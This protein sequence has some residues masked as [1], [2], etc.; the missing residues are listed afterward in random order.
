MATWFR[1]WHLKKLHWS[2]LLFCLAC[3]KFSV[4]DLTHK[5]W[6]TSNV[7]DD[8][9]VCCVTLQIF[10]RMSG[11]VINRL[12]LHEL[13]LEG[14]SVKDLRGIGAVGWFVEEK[15][16]K[17]AVECFGVLILGSFVEFCDNRLLV[18]VTRGYVKLLGKNCA[19][20]CRFEYLGAIA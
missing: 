17:V 8:D 13:V 15:K 16:G 19:R 9:D 6:H 2:W 1:F 18:I 3:S 20:K 4:T 10:M 7:T 5:N 12:F 14:I 11:M